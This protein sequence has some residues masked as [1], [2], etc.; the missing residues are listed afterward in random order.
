MH[1]GPMT[2]KPDLNQA[3]K[4]WAAKIGPEAVTIRLITRGVNVSVADKLATGRYPSKPR[5]LLAKVLIEEMAKDG[6]ELAGEKAS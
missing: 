1:Y 4:K 2:R 6:F 3:V 5:N